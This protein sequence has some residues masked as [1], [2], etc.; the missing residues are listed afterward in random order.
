MRC[1]TIQEATHLLAEAQELNPGP[2]VQHSVYVA[3]AAELI[4]RHH[5]DLDAETAFVLGYLHDIGRRFGVTDNRHILDGYL[6]LQEQGYPDAA[7]IA[8]T[9]SFPIQNPYAVAGHWDCTEEEFR[10]V[11]DALA[12]VVYT[13]YDSLLQLCDALALPTG[14][15][16]LEKRFVDVS[17][18]RGINEYTVARWQA[19]LDIQQAFE[20]E[21]GRS[22]YTILPGIVENTFGFGG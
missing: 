22:I 9:H 20:A 17:L 6:F 18:R 21:I 4:A 19:Y 3:R 7:R 8:L 2:W 12:Q 10:I 11:S 1:P 16:L 5:P 13:K 15:C 14:F